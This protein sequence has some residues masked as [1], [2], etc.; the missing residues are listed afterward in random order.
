VPVNPFTQDCSHRHHDLRRSHVI[1]V[2]PAD[3]PHAV[4]SAAEVE[5]A[6]EHG[7]RVDLQHRQPFTREPVDEHEHAHH[8]VI[9]ARLLLFKRLVDGAGLL[10]LRVVLGLVV[11]VRTDLEGTAAGMAGILPE[12]IV[13]VL[14]V[15]T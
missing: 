4:D 2:L 14:A 8:P 11:L 3:V 12:C 10:D 6:D 5:R 9:L 7:K 1:D 13:R 15:P